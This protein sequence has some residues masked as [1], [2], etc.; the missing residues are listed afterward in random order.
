[1]SSRMK[2]MGSLPVEE[3]LVD[4]AQ[5]VIPMIGLK[6]PQSLRERFLARLERLMNAEITLV[7]DAAKSEMLITVALAASPGQRELDDDVYAFL[8]RLQTCLRRIA[9][10]EPGTIGETTLVKRD[11]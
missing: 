11:D 2:A 10:I 9:S 1:M 7:G 5:G 3:N 4:D 8:G 6:T